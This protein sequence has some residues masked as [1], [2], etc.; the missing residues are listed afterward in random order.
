MKSLLPYALITLITLFVLRLFPRPI[1]HVI[2]G[3]V[4]I[5]LF[6]IWLFREYEIRLTKKNK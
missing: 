4:L 1:G 6:A 3:V 2:V 5:V